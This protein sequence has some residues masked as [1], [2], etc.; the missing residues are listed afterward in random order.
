MYSKNAVASVAIEGPGVGQLQAAGL[1][2]ADIDAVDR[3]G[4]RGFRDALRQRDH[5]ATTLAEGCEEPIGFLWSFNAESK[6]EAS[7]CFGS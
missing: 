4:T 6:R 5:G 1:Q 3:E 2:A 7:K